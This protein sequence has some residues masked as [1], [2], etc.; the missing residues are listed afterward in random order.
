VHQVETGLVAEEEIEGGVGFGVAEG[1]DETVEI[2]GGG[3]MGFHAGFEGAHLGGP[4]AVE[5]PVGGDHFVDEG[6]F[7]FVGGMEAVEV[8]LAEGLEGFLVF[9]AE[10]QGFGEQAVFEGVLRGDG[11]ALGSFGA[12]RERAVGAVG[13]EFLFGCREHAFLWMARGAGEHPSCFHYWDGVS[14]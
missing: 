5:A 3:G 2:G 10:D 9:M 12:A 13:S 1:Q 7:D 4:G 14:K 11:F 6:E 8:G